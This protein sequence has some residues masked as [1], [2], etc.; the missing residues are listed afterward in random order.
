VPTVLQPEACDARRG[1]DSR[2][3]VGR[4]DLGK[5]ARSS[6]WRQMI[7]GMRAYGVAVTG[8]PSS[9]WPSRC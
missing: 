2:L 1:A 3:Q 5:P 6:V 4:P 9:S 8:Q 7:S